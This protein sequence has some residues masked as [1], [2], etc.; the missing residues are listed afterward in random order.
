MSLSPSLLRKIQRLFLVVMA[1]AIA[2]PLARPGLAALALDR[3]EALL[4]YGDYDAYHRVLDRAIAIDPGPLEMADLG[5]L[6][7]LNTA[8]DPRDLRRFHDYLHSHPD[9]D[10]ELWWDEALLDVRKKQYDR[11]CYA[12]RHTSTIHSI[13]LAR[14]TSVIAEKTKRQCS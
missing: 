3:G 10:A 7:T 12:L 11:A 14:F 5:N 8:A 1:I 4:I 2:Y 13:P 6:V 9:A